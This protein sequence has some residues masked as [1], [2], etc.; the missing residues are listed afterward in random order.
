MQWETATPAIASFP[1][2]L[3]VS[4]GFALVLFL[5]ASVIATGRTSADLQ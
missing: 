3:T 1:V 4:V 2:S 5:L